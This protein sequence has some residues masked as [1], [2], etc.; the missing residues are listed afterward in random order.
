M[1]RK[2]LISANAAI[3]N[4]SET[5]AIINDN[6]N[7]GLL[8]IGGYGEV[9]SDSS[10][11]LN[12]TVKAAGEAT[13][14]LV[15]AQ[16][17]VRANAA[18]GRSNCQCTGRSKRHGDDPVR[19]LPVVLPDCA[20]GDAY[21][22]ANGDYTFTADPG[23][24]YGFSATVNDEYI[25]VI[26]NGDGSYTI[27]NV[28]GELVISA[29]SAPTVKTLRGDRQGRRLRRRQR[30]H[31]RNAWAELYLYGH[32]GGQ[33][34]LCGGRNGKQPAGDVHCQQ[35]RQQRLYLHDPG[36]VRHRPGGH[37]GEEGPAK[38][39]HANRAYGQRLRRCLG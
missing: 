23:Y 24:N 29:N 26:D 1:T 34:R 37:Y 17:D 22:T 35:Q 30:P 5:P 14:K 18:K 15:K 31:F 12:F 6:S 32:A 9:R 10:I 3:G 39:H 38:R 16:M 33:L 27:K 11:M 7:A 8:T 20:T 25:D 36:K 2:S 4:S 19:R 13:V 21:V 28:T